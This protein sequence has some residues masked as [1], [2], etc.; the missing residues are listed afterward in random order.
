MHFMQ[1][2]LS[3]EVTL[4]PSKFIHIGGDEVEKRPWK[5]NPLAQQRMRELDFKNEEEL[6]S[7]FVRQMDNFSLRTGAASWAGTRFL[8]AGSLPVP[9]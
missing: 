2:V 1:D 8:R 5:A 3:E 7:W 9:R 4:F 6:Q